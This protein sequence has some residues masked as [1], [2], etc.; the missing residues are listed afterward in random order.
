MAKLYNYKSTALN[1]FTI[2]TRATH[3]LC[4]LIR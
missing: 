4:L 1:S 2:Q 3:C